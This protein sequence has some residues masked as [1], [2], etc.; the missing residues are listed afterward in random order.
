MEKIPPQQLINQLECNSFFSFLRMVKPN[1]FLSRFCELSA[2]FATLL[3]KT[4]NYLVVLPKKPFNVAIRRKGLHFFQW[5]MNGL[6]KPLL[7]LFTSKECTNGTR[8]SRFVCGQAI[9]VCLEK[10]KKKHTTGMVLSCLVMEM[11]PIIFLTDFSLNC[12]IGKWSNTDNLFGQIYI[13][14]WQ[15]SMHRCMN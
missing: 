8:F 14:S 11:K 10:R 1:E 7:F 9:V 2:W 6:R 15:C 12:C 13:I 5:G 4:R 3:W